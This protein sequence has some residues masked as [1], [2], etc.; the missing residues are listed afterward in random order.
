MD[1]W[2]YTC[3]YL[4]CKVDLKCGNEICDLRKELLKTKALKLAMMKRIHID[5]LIGYQYINSSSLLALGP[6]FS[7][8]LFSNHKFHFPLSNLLC[9]TS[10]NIYSSK[11]PFNKDLFCFLKLIETRGFKIHFIRIYNLLLGK[12]NFSQIFLSDNVILGSK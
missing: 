8:I 6:L 5:S 10:R 12:Y 7:I 11:N 4:Y 9:N 1:F 2:N 3:S